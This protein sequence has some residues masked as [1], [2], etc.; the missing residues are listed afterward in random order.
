MKN[1]KYKLLRQGIL[2]DL[3]G[4]VTMLIP[5]IGPFLDILW[6]PLAAKKMHSMYKGTSGKVASVIVFVE[7]LIPMTDLIPTFTIMWI[8]TFVLSPQKTTQ[9]R[10]FNI[11]TR[12]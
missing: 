2:F 5:V 12:N 7:E 1:K 10:A 9:P 6:A 8:Y 11:S 3:I 4:M